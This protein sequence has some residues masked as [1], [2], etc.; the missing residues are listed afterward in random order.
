M[1]NR[2]SLLSAALLTTLLFGC[3]NSSNEGQAPE[4]DAALQPVSTL[5]AIAERAD[6]A[7][8]ARL[9]LV[10][11]E[12]ELNSLSVLSQLRDPV[13]IAPEDTALSILRKA[14]SE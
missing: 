10:A 11:I 1:R 2:L 9:N 14:R 5:E 13:T 3:D 12:S 4:V 8:S 6:D 7:E